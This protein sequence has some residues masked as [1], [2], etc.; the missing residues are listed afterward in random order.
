MYYLVF[1]IGTIFL[2]QKKNEN[3]NTLVFLFIITGM[4][5]FRY[6]VGPD[7]FSYK[8]LY[9][10]LNTN[11]FEEIFY[12]VGYE[13]VFFRGLGS[14]LKKLGFSYQQYISF[15][16][17]INLFF[18]Y[19]T[20]KKNCVNYFMALFIY[21][22]FFYFT[23]TFNII[24]QG[25]ALS[26]GIYYYIES[27][28]KSQSIKFVIISIFIS[29]IHSSA[30]ILIPLY[31]ISR[32]G[33]TRFRLCI[34]SLFCIIVSFLPINLIVGKMGE[35]ILMRRI[36][37]YYLDPSFFANFLSFK[38]MARL[39]FLIFGIVFYGVYRNKSYVH[40]KIM[41][42]YLISLNLYFVLRFSE[43]TASRISIYGFIL[44]ML[45]LPEI[46]DY[47]YNY[48]HIIGYKITLL[49][50][51]ILFFQKELSTMANLSDIFIEKT[52]VV[53]YTNIYN[54]KE[55]NNRTKMEEK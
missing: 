1:F 20:C 14:I 48:Y 27:L 55:L 52:K 16:S 50:V 5:I 38:I 45:I 7:Y 43:I 31:F 29:C 22:C 6:G 21:Y 42:T 35:F 3:I 17:G 41:N 18:I 53:Q 15:I 9:I 24:R 51:C 40:E 34:F 13:E 25:L 8:K 36:A 37:T 46:F 30:T 10:Q 4:A 47:L 19:K 28:K 54:M 39:I 49:F 12:G 33:W 26:I 11:F 44:L 32:L 23:W 2:F